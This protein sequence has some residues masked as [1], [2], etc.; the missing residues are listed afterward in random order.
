VRRIFAAAALSLTVASMAVVASPYGS[1]F[2]RYTKHCSH[3]GYAHGYCQRVHYGRWVGFHVPTF[4][5]HQLEVYVRQFRAYKVDVEIE[6]VA[7]PSGTPS[8]AVCFGL[9]LFNS[10]TGQPITG[11]VRDVTFDHPTWEYDQATGKWHKVAN[12]HGG[13]LFY[14]MP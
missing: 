1:V 5:H 10:Q 4:H 14:F 13:G 11:R 3:H 8:G 6:Y 12:S 2:A 7:C 9:D